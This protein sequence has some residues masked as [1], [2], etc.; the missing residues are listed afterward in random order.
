MAYQL[1]N[2]PTSTRVSELSTIAVLYLVQDIITSSDSAVH[3][4]FRLWI[5]L[6]MDKGHSLPG[7]FSLTELID[8]VKTECAKSTLFVL[9]CFT[10][11][12]HL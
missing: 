5:T 9:C 10:H 3:T 4:D 12:A 1:P 2:L 6:Q 8:N 11:F 7:E